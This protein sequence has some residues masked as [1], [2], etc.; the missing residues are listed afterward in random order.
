MEKEGG[1]ALERNVNWSIP[2]N[3]HPPLLFLI[4]VRKIIFMFI[5]LHY[6]SGSG[7]RV[8]ILLRVLIMMMIACVDDD[9]VNM[10]MVTIKIAGEGDGA[11]NPMGDLDPWL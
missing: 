2:Y 7:Q 5:V 1:S 10:V 4:I 11:E 8:P 6:L 9:N 3:I